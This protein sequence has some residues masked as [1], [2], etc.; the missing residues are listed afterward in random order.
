MPSTDPA[1]EAE[2]RP[3]YTPEMIPLH[4]GWLTRWLVSVESER[5]PDNPWKG[6][7]EVE[8]DAV[9]HIVEIDGMEMSPAETRNYARALDQAADHAEGRNIDS[10]LG[11]SSR[12]ARPRGRAQAQDWIQ[13]ARNRA[14]AHIAR[15]S[16]E[17]TD[18]QC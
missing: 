6:W 4:E 17:A 9:S 1:P 13:A 11:D 2:P 16:G 10:D 15:P 18:A 5:D 8:A 7:A 14:L 12:R 3:P